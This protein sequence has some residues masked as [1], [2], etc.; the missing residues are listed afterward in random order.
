MAGTAVSTT[1][2]S[3]LKNGGN[4][5]RSKSWMAVPAMTGITSGIQPIG[6]SRAARAVADGRER[7]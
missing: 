2:Q 3:S 6:L 1:F 4:M 5:P 7:I